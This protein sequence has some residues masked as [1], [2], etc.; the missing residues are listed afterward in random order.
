[1]FRKFLT[2]FVALLFAAGASYAAFN[3]SF[4]R[5]I[6]NNSSLPVLSACGTG[7]LAAG[8]SDSAG[9]FTATGATGCTLTFG[10]AYASAPSCSVTELTIN[11]A[12]RTTAIT[13][14]TLVVAAGGSGSTYS[15]V[16]MAKAGG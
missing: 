12:A 8:S 13:T 1:M 15:Y 2:S 10:T 3:T 14:T 9:T 4:D 11:T 5:L 6:A 7:T 16:C